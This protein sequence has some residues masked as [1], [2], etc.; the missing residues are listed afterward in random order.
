MPG[1]RELPLTRDALRQ[2]GLHVD[3]VWTTYTGLTTP[4]IVYVHWENE[5]N[6]HEMNVARHIVVAR[7]VFD[8]EPGQDRPW[9]G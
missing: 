1:W 2:R 9:C 7:K 4:D 8:I 6:R 3:G 5:P